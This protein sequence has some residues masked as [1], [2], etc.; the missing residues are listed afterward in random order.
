MNRPLNTHSNVN[1]PKRSSAKQATSSLSFVASAPNSAKVLV[2]TEENSGKWRWVGA[3]IALG[4]A[5]SVL[6]TVFFFFF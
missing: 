1:S 6:V 4:S 3:L 2:G 5:I